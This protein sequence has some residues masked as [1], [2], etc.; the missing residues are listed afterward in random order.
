MRPAHCEWSGT[1]PFLACFWSTRHDAAD[2]GVSD[3]LPLALRPHD[4]GDA[5]YMARLPPQAD[6]CQQ[7]PSAESQSRVQSES[8][9]GVGCRRCRVPGAA[10]RCRAAGRQ[11]P[12]GGGRAQSRKGVVSGR[13]SSPSNICHSHFHEGKVQSGHHGRDEYRG[14]LQSYVLL[15]Q[16]FCASGRQSLLDA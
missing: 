8:G 13:R 2:G 10:G 1:S 16:E 9:Q 14:C 4:A 6:R 11:V 5:G 7:V 12:G 3:T 15:S